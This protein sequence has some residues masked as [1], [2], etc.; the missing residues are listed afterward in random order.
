[1]SA[2]GSV[3]EFPWGNPLAFVLLGYGGYRAGRALRAQWSFA[4]LAG[5]AAAVL[6]W[7]GA[8]VSGLALLGVST[9]VT[10]PVLLAVV[11]MDAGVLLLAVVSG[12]LR[13]VAA[14]AEPLLTADTVLSHPA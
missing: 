7:G 13:P 11:A 3:V 1:M 10:V 2:F 12:Q 14:R 5:R 6:C 8:I 9:P 4:P